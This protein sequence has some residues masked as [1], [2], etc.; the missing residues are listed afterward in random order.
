MTFSLYSDM[1]RQVYNCWSTCVKLVWNVNRATKS[2]LVENLLTG[3][4]PSIRYTGLLLWAVPECLSQPN[5]HDQNTCVH[6]CFRYL[7]YYLIKAAQYYEGILYWSERKHCKILESRVPVLD[8]ERCGIPCPARYLV[9]RHTLI[10]D[11]KDTGEVGQIR[12]SFSDLQIVVKLSNEVPRKFWV[13]RKFGSFFT[14]MRHF[15]VIFQKN[16][17]FWVIFHEIDTFF[18]HFSRN[19]DLFGSFFTRFCRNFLVNDLSFK[20]HFALFAG[21]LFLSTK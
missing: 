16:R 21:L 9:E 5:T 12:Y 20:K 3:G 14:K 17:H 7:E 6:C 4:L 8:L 11:N 15:W 2:F 13:R 1:A 18:G 19:W 10:F